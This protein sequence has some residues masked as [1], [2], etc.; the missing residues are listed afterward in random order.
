M[1][2]WAA[3]LPNSGASRR[4]TPSKELSK[5][6]RR[7]SGSPWPSTA[8]RPL[9]PANQA[10]STTAAA[11]K[12]V[13]SKGSLQGCCCHSSVP[14]LQEWRGGVGEEAQ[15]SGSGASASS[16]LAFGLGDGLL[17]AGSGAASQPSVVAL[18]QG[19]QQNTWG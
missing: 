9:F 17:G 13:P 7:S 15:A 1:N 11:A 18:T 10:T 19:S 8:N 3:A 12:P 16:W 4:E 14:G 5:P 2:N 6:C